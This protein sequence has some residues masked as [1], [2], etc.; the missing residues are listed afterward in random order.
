M[1]EIYRDNALLYSSSAPEELEENDVE[2]PNY[3]WAA[4]YPVDFFN[5]PANV[6]L[7]ADNTSYANILSLLAGSLRYPF[8]AH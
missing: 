4:Y 6:V 7:Y 3:D 8:D 5:G 2:A 1:T